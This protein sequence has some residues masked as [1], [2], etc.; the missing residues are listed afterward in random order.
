[1]HKKSY[2]GFVVGL[3]VYLAL[4]LGIAFIPAA[5]EQLPMRLVILLTAWYMA[6]L[7]LQVWKT[8]QIYWYNGTTFED[9]EA[10]GSQRRKAFAW[11]HFLIFG[12]YALIQTA[13]ALVMVLLGWSA[14]ID[15]S[16]GTVGLC[17]AAF[18]TMPIKL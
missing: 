14:W 10:A 2:K 5:D 13:V 9:A 11:R 16:V 12:R 7:S 4:L 3:L 1:M 8:E 17:I 18:M 6:A 15:F